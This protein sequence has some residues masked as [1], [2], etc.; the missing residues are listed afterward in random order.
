MTVEN[1]R[2]TRVESELFDNLLTV[3][4]FFNVC[5]IRLGVFL[6]GSFVRNKKP[7][8][9]RHLLFSEKR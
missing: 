5:V 1:F 2:G 6:V 3:G 9:G 4:F 8:E 7:F